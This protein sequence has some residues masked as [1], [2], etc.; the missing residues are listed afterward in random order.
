MLRTYRLP[1][2]TSGKSL[3][4]EGVGLEPTSPFGRRFSSSEARILLRPTLL[5]DI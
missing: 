3:K 2:D 1:L 4:A 5:D